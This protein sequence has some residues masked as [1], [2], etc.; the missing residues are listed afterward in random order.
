MSFYDRIKIMVDYVETLEPGDYSV[1]NWAA[2]EEIAN[3][4]KEDKHRIEIWSNPVMLTV[5]DVQNNDFEL[6]VSVEETTLQQGESFTQRKKNCL[7]KLQ[8]TLKILP[9]KYKYI[10]NMGDVYICS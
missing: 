1:E 6:T 3:T 7:K 8:K 2:I 4:G 5:T 10:L 9:K